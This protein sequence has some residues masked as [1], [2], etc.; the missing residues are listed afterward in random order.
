MRDLRS[1][2]VAGARFSSGCERDPGGAPCGWT[3][4]DEA[5]GS[6]GTTVRGRCWSCAEMEERC[7]VA[8][9]E[10]TSKRMMNRL[11]MV[12]EWSLEF[13]A[14]SL[15]RCRVCRQQFPQLDL[16]TLRLPSLTRPRRGP[17][18]AWRP[19]YLRRRLHRTPRARRFR[20]KP[21]RDFLRRASCPAR[22]G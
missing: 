22:R 10:A 11:N 14:H 13:L 16:P 6:A 17:R 20:R 8:V 15:S 3:G 12:I 9:H 19:R 1:A 18:L 5:D 4:R 2:R 21:D 7:S